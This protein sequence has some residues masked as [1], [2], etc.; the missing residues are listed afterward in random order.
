MWEH[1]WE[2]GRSIIAV[3]VSY[4]L[5]GNPLGLYLINVLSFVTKKGAQP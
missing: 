3:Y 5:T 2:H 4:K 1:C